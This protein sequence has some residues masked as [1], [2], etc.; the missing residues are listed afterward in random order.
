M[1]ARI[2]HSAGLGFR[3]AGQDPIPPVFGTTYDIYIRTRLTEKMYNQSP[4]TIKNHDVPHL[5]NS[6]SI[7]VFRSHESENN[8]VFMASMFVGQDRRLMLFTSIVC[9]L[10]IFIRFSRSPLQVTQTDD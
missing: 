2:K 7:Y 9:L 8:L 3:N 10:L 5:L 1:L 6:R 4:T